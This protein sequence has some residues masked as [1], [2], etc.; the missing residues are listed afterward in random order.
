MS[1]FGSRVIRI[2]LSALFHV[3]WRVERESEGI[4]RG[5][6]AFPPLDAA[7]AQ[8]LLK[9]TPLRYFPHTGALRGFECRCCSQQIRTQVHWPLNARTRLSLKKRLALVGQR[10]R[11]RWPNF[12]QD[13]HQRDGKCG[14][15]W[16]HANTKA[17]RSERCSFSKA[18]PH[19]LKTKFR[20]PKVSILF[21]INF[22]YDNCKNKRFEWHNYICNLI[23]DTLPSI[24]F[25]VFFS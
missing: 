5:L 4:H 13:E 25:I 11:E 3:K 20:I 15:R 18:W 9:S 16:A 10:E 17:P 19:L 14:W 21:L 6:A 12:Y 7:A 22:D 1:R 2:R 8:P 24:L 23:D